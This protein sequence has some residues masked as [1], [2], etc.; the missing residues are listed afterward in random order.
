MKKNILLAVM[1]VLFVGACASDNAKNTKVQPDWVMSESQQYPRSKY[2]TGVG[3]ADTMEDAKS[4]ARAELA[5]IFNVTVQSTSS[6]LSTYEQSN[7]Q[8][9]NAL[10]VSRDIN[11][12]T[13]QR[14][15]GVNV[16][17]LWKNPVAQ[18]YYALATLPR[19]LTGMNLRGDISQLD[20]ATSTLITRIQQSNSLVGK[21]R[22]SNETIPLQHKRRILN[23]QLQ[24]VSLT[25]QSMPEQ[26]SVEKL[27]MDRAALIA[28]I[29]IT[30]IAT[31]FSRNKMQTALEDALAGQG[32][33][34]IPDGD[35]QMK[36]DLD[37]NPLP[38]QGKWYYEKANLSLSLVGEN[39]KSLGGYAW[40]FKVSSS[41]PTLTEL[42]VLEQA[43]KRLNTELK[44]K[45]FDLLEK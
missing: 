27:Q 6:D 44:T 12:S 16:V 24:V 29:T 10:A 15:E 4:R 26:W 32:F 1:V 41:D 31:G 34:V 7:G 3:E 11:T 5:K 37:T 36:V 2:L 25:G 28:R 40:D 23:K 17:E 30:P 18:R 9:T 13:K 38:R 35:Y 8:T 19:Q 45:F 21:I 43:K 22:L 20:S 42:R 33:T 14:L 39:K